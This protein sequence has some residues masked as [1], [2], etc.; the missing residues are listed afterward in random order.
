MDNSDAYLS[1]QFPANHEGLKSIVNEI[2]DFKLYVH[3]FDGEHMLNLQLC[4]RKSDILQ[5]ACEK[6]KQPH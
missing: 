2:E 3:I 1:W 5:F 4:I 6:K